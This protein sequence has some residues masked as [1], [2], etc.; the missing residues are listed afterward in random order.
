MGWTDIDLHACTNLTST[1]AEPDVK[2]DV[3][4][5]TAS[6]SDVLNLV[7]RDAQGAR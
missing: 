2:P 3:K 1:M 5:S 4:P 7:I 6:S